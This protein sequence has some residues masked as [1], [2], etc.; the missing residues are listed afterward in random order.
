M[1][2]IGHASR[3]LHVIKVLASG[4]LTLPSGL[5]QARSLVINM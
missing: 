4:L 3:V 5:K 2:L 1:L